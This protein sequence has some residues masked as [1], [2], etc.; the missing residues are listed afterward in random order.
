MSTECKAELIRGKCRQI[1]IYCLNYSD[2]ERKRKIKDPFKLGQ[3]HGHGMARPRL[4]Q[5]KKKK[6]RQIPLT[7]KEKNNIQSVSLN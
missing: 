6:K 3:K 1:M 7:F 4:Y 5:K 2:K